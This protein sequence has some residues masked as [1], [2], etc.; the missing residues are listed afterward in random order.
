MFKK[1]LVPTDGSATALQ[2]AKSARALAEKFGSEIT[3]L[4]IIPNYYS[5]PAFSTPDTVT[6]PAS[7]MDDLETNGKQILEKTKEIFAGFEGKI[8][9]RLEYGS[10]AKKTCAIAKDEAFSLIAMGRRGLGGVAELLLGSVSNQIVHAAPCPTLVVQGPV[11][12]D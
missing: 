1:I 6:I 5:L 12:L 9:A 8:T 4:H 2:A 3:L 11:D 7:V 10:P